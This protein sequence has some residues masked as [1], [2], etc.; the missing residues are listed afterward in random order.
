VK[1]PA[2]TAALSATA[3]DTFETL[4]ADWKDA[5]SVLDWRCL[6]MLPPWLKAWWSVFGH[7]RVAHLVGI[8]D[9]G[10][11][12][13][14]APLMVTDETARFIGDADLCDYMDVV[15]VPGR[16]K[17]VVATLLS[18]LCRKGLRYLDLRALRPDS[19][20]LKVLGEV[21]PQQEYR[22]DCRSEDVSAEVRL[23][24]SWDGFL[25]QLTGKQ[26]HEIRRKFRRLRNAGSVAF[27]LVADPSQV[28]D[29]MEIFLR[30]F[31]ANRDDKARFMTAERTS[32]FRRLAQATADAGMLRLFFL[33]LDGVPVAAVMGFDFRH[34]R[35]LYNNGYDRRY[36]SLSV[37]L[38]SKIYSIRDAIENGLERYDF[39]TGDESY[40]IR[41]GGDPVP[42]YR[43]RVALF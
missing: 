5:A 32:F 29:A 27:R 14:V 10:R 9:G 39:L 26:R 28:P 33:Y 30:L 2:T 41:L 12:I 38:L 31:T 13:G 18:H 3:L 1:P 40:K 37:G 34:T 36:R 16:E 21:V 15:S 42:I 35:Y 11:R 6:C 4:E 22:S 7:D 23:S 17:D 19:S 43:C 8:E 24:S 25:K 20:I